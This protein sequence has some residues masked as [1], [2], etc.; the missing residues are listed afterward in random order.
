MVTWRGRGPIDAQPAADQAAPRVDASSARVALAAVARDLVVLESDVV[1]DDPLKWPGYRD[2]L[3]AAHSRCGESE[4]VISAEGTV[5]GRRSTLIAFDFGFLG[6]SIG[7][8]TGRRITHAIDHARAQRQPL[9]SLVASG[10]ARMQEGMRSLVQLQH[11]AAAC[12]QA[13]RS[14]VAHVSV[15][16]DPTTGGAWVALASNADVIIAVDHAKASFAGSRVRA[17]AI[18][19]P[20]FTAQGKWGAGF[21]DV[22]I[23]AEDVP[24]LLDRYVDLL[25]GAGAGAGAG[26]DPEPCPVPECLGDSDPPAS[27]WEAVRRARSGRRPRASE[28]LDH[29]FSE[30]VAISGDRVGGRD[31]GML[32]GVGRSDGQTVAYAAQ[33]GTQNT[34]AGFRTVTRLLRLADRLRLPVLTLIDTPGADDTAAAEQ[35]GIG[36][37]IG[38][39]FAAMSEVSVPVTSLL[40]GEGGSGGA[41]GLAGRHGFW[42]TPDSYFSV[43]SPEGAASILYRDDRRAPDI[44]EL[45]QLGPRDL[46]RLGISSGVCGP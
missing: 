23:A 34:P 17:R 35:G 37:A 15:V 31:D 41:L 4:S 44:A 27:G 26:P 11:L 39:T 32:C 42:T 2:Q 7:E 9:V 8:A 21:V 40:I 12:A 16:R 25:G 18:D 46:E 14:G 3:S 36:T 43:I 13:R 19:S 6:G 33:T 22:T 20:Q 1:S 30:R 28:Y 38:E 10:G 24:P 29:Y 45:L 5:G